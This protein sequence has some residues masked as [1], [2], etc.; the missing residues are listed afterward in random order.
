M[1]HY[2]MVLCSYIGGVTY[3]EKTGKEPVIFLK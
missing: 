1:Y 3:S 2:I